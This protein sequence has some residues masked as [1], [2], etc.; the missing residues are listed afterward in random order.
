MVF[1]NISNAVPVPQTP[2]IHTLIL[3]T[4]PQ[5]RK[6]RLLCR[7]LGRPRL[8]RRPRPHP[9]RPA[10]PIPPTVPSPFRPAP[11]PSR[12]PTCSLP[13]LRAR[14]RTR[15]R[16][17]HDRRRHHPAGAAARSSPRPTPPPPAFWHAPLALAKP[18]AAAARHTPAAADHS[19][20]A[21]HPPPAPRPR[22]RRRRPPNDSR[23]SSPPTPPLPATRKP[24][25]VPGNPAAAA[26]HLS[27]PPAPPPRPFGPH[28][29]GRRRHAAGFAARPSPRPTSSPP[30]TCHVP[31]ADANP[32]PA[33]HP[34]ITHA[35]AAGATGRLSSP[36]T[37]P[38][39]P[40]SPRHHRRR[41]PPR[42]LSALLHLAPS[43]RTSAP[44]T[45]P[46]TP[47][48]PPHTIKTCIAAHRE[49]CITGFL[50]NRLGRAR[51]PD[52]RRRGSVGFPGQT[53]SPHPQ[54]HRMCPSG[55]LDDQLKPP[56]DFVSAAASTIPAW[57]P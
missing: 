38:P 14:C 47:L 51:G 23:P 35:T 13:S 53:T 21:R 29:H 37:P 26:A 18:A 19:A 44:P 50:E 28:H 40:H 32:A 11:P 39:R 27:S 22:Q 54:D 15:P 24:P 55:Y 30:A 2:P 56:A 33:R 4:P 34:P 9:C 12:P 42:P 16:P 5:T 8:R 31:P 6:R 57:R 3:P 20:A 1:L 43:Q 41:P 45:L 46:G 36:L 10:H 52:P 17:R 49:L 25:Q 7:G 48:M